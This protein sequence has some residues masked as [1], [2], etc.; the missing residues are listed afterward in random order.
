MRLMEEANE[1]AE[2]KGCCDKELSTN[3]PTRHKKTAA[4]ETLHAEINQLEA[5]IAKLSDDIEELAKDVAELTSKRVKAT[6]PR[7]EEK[8]TNDETIAVVRGSLPLPQV[9][10]VAPVDVRLDHCL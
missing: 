1:E 2:H 6:K 5:S 10:H 8:E 3:E 7:Q 4:V 9:R